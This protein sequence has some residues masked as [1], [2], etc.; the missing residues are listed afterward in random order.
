[1]EDPR[2]EICDLESQIRDFRSGTLD[3]NVVGV[4]MRRRGVAVI[5]YLG[6]MNPRLET[7]K[8]LNIC[9]TVKR[10]RNK[11]TDI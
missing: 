1:M 3:L 9:G 7:W 6:F 5:L 11:L 10:A 4:R 2:S 8:E